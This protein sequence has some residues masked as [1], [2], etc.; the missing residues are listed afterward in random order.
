MHSRWRRNPFPS[1][2]FNRI[3]PRSFAA[4]QFIEGLAQIEI[5]DM[6]A[7][8]GLDLN[9][10][11]VNFYRSQK[12]DAKIGKQSKIVISNAMA[13][14]INLDIGDNSEADILNTAEIGKLEAKMSNRS[15]IESSGKIGE[16]SIFI[17]GGSK[18]NIEKISKSPIII[19]D[20]KFKNDITDFLHIA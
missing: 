13:K 19:T 10:T 1:F 20:E 14:S 18:L 5:S 2:L 17:T 3:I 7:A 9:A 12:L 15:E 6:D 16:A 8:V 11:Y 4:R